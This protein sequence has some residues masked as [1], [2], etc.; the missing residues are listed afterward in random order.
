VSFPL[1]RIA[2]CST[3]GSRVAFVSTVSPPPP[4]AGMACDSE[5]SGD[6]SK[7]P[8][9]MVIKRAGKV[10]NLEAA[11]LESGLDMEQL[12]SNHSGI[13]HTRWATH[14]P[15]NEVSSAMH[16]PPNSPC[17]TRQRWPSDT[18]S[19]LMRVCSPSFPF[20]VVTRVCVLFALTSFCPP[21]I[22]PSDPSS[23]SHPR[24]PLVSFPCNGA[25]S[26]REGVSLP[27]F[28]LIF[29]SLRSS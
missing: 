18:C 28:P 13:A 5:P 29:T 12:V 8:A 20:A 7:P 10:A 4:C 15:P 25:S 1:I 24:P 19:Q 17:C 14:G 3:W 9:T 11:V 16:L 21:A 6:R 23:R 22:G 27:H 26:L 2:H